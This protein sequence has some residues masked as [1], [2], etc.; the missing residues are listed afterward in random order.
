MSLAQSALA[1]VW[2]W[3]LPDVLSALRYPAEHHLA[4]EELDRMVALRGID[5]A[6]G[7]LVERAVQKDGW[8]VPA[9]ALLAGA[10][11]VLAAADAPPMALAF[12]GS[13]RTHLKSD[14]GNV[15][16]RSSSSCAPRM[17]RSSRP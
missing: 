6:A 7:L 2:S 10:F 11:D 12:L 9:Q 1:E 8:Q 16:R 4:A 17:I 15:G 14:G 5:F 3:T 13:A